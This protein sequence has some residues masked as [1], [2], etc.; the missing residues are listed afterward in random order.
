[1]GVTP[2]QYLER[3][4]LEQAEKLLRFGSLQI[5]EVARAVGYA[6][7]EYFA[8]RF[9]R[10]SGHSPREFRRAAGYD[11]GYKGR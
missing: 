2:M 5:G 7:P 9:R 8:N 6:D 10:H 3:V 4:R 11:V 1:M